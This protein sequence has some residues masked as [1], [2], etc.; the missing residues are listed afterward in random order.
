LEGEDTTLYLVALFE[1]LLVIICILYA[2]N[3]KDAALQFT[4]TR[5]WTGNIPHTA[6]LGLI[7]GKVN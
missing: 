2:F 4:Y 3:I 1:E 6:K 5:Y 7:V